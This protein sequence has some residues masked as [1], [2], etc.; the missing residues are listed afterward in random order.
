MDNNDYYMGHFTPI[1]NKK[2]IGIVEYPDSGDNLDKML[3]LRFE[4]GT[5]AWILSDGEGNGP[6]WLDIVVPKVKV[7]KEKV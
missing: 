5:I 7:K 4:D 2:V 3:G 1:M 6:G